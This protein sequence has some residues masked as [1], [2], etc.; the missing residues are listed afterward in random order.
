LSQRE[1]RTK[2]EKEHAHSNGEPGK[3][4]KKTGFCIPVFIE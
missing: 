3:A 1:I 4:Y 2:K